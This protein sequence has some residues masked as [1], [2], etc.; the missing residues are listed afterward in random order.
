MGR[1]PR[2]THQWLQNLY[3]Y[4][5][6]IGAASPALGASTGYIAFYAATGVTGGQQIATGTVASGGP[7]GTNA[8][9]TAWTNGGISGTYY[10]LS[11]VVGALKTTG[12]LK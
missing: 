1:T 5:D 12:F 3:N 8:A 9:S 6:G 11:D 7:S 4:L 10:T 2:T